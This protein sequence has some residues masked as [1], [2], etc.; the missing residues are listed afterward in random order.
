MINLTTKR[1]GGFKFD[2]VLK[3]EGN[4]SDVIRFEVFYL[5][6]MSGKKGV[7][8]SIRPTTLEQGEGYTSE[9]FLLYNQA[10]ISVFAKQLVRKN[11]R[12]VLAIAEKIDAQVPALLDIYQQ[13]GDIRA[14]IATAV[15]S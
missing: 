1:N 5:K 6:T 11:D 14:A 12:E 8:V 2:R 13:G 15:Q 7:F 3:T 4:K 9:S 10:N